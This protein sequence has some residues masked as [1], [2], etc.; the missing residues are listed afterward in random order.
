MPRYTAAITAV[1]ADGAA[2]GSKVFN[3]GTGIGTVITGY[4]EEINYKYAVDADTSDLRVY[5]IRNGVEV[6]IFTAANTDGAGANVTVR[7]RYPIHT[8]AGAVIEDVVGNDGD[9]PPVL[10]TS[11][12]GET[13][14]YFNKEKV[15]AAV[16][17]TDAGAPAVTVHM[18]V[19]P[20]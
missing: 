3:G 12:R 15:Y 5:V 16:D 13:R 14:W 17:D 10:L 2:L 9:D 6:D 20:T 4:L 18:L 11:Q 7:P 19:S 1:G 8:E